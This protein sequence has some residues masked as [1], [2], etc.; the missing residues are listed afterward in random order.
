MKS[1]DNPQS[2][3]PEIDAEIPENA[4]RIYGQQDAMDDFPVLK[5]FQQYIDSEQAKARKRL[6]M[7]CVFFGL[8]MT[9]VISVFLVLLLNVSTRNQQLNDR[10]VE[11]AMKER[12]RA[13]A[14]IVVQPQTQQQDNATILAITA[15]MDEMRKSFDESRK[16]AAEA[17]ARHKAAEEAEKAALAAKNAL[18]IKRL[19]ERLAAQKAEFEKQQSELK[20]LT[21][22]KA[23]KEA[24]QAAEKEK[25]RKRQEELEAYRRKHYPDLYEKKR[26]SEPEMVKTNDDAAHKELLKEVDQILSDDDAISYYDDEEP[27]KA[28]PKPT[29][30]PK[31]AA[32]APKKEYSIPV[33]IRGSSGRWSVPND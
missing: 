28:K 12:E 3:I 11:Y 9:I 26:P 24:R 21:E 19:N 27:V 10:M 29:P 1:N 20:K 6:L 25:E 17:E 7:L 2:E 18:E 13:A 8:L 30:A 31:P 33:D 23:R 15:K 16:Q 22:E 4:V 5:A 14:P 32:S